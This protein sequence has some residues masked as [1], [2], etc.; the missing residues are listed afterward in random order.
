VTSAAPQLQGGTVTALAHTGSER[1]PDYP[2]VP[3]FKDLGYDIVATNWFGLAGP[4]GLSD[5]IVQK[6]NRAINAGMAT[7]ANQARIRQ[8]AI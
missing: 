3:T 1:L 2:D 7:P 8:E 6:V 5:D 4:A